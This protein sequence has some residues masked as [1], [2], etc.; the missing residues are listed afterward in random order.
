MYNL[1]A[2]GDRASGGES[3]LDLL[4]ESPEDNR[5]VPVIPW[6][7][8]L[9]E[10]HLPA[11][12]GNLGVVP[13][14]QM[15]WMI[16][17]TSRNQGPELPMSMLVPRAGVQVGGIPMKSRQVSFHLETDDLPLLMQAVRDR[18]I[19]RY[20]GIP[21]FL[22]MTVLKAEAGSRLEIV[23][24]SFWDNNLEG[25]ELEAARF[26]EEI[27]DATGG[28][29]TQRGFDTLYAQIRNSDGAFDPGSES[30]SP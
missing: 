1:Q 13:P 23:V 15:A 25:S 4:G 24:T 30:L 6:V 29:P 11:R 12:V 22:G 14:L 18:V 2:H 28:N 21:Q 27:V 17:D 3:K 7:R 26:I 20:E 19:P 8:T 9:G 16:R 5:F 10:C